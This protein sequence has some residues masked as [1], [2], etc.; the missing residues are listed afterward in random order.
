MPAPDLPPWKHLNPQLVVWHTTSHLA[1]RKYMD[2]LADINPGRC[3]PYTLTTVQIHS[4]YSFDAIECP[5]SDKHWCDATFRCKAL[6]SYRGC[7]M[8][9]YQREFTERKAFKCV[10]MKE[11]YIEPAKNR[12]ATFAK[13]LRPEAVQYLKGLRAQG[14]YT[15]AKEEKEIAE[16]RDSLFDVLEEQ[17]E[18]DSAVGES[19]STQRAASTEE[20]VDLFRLHEALN[21]MP[22]DRVAT[23]IESGVVLNADATM[24]CMDYS[25]SPDHADLE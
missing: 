20:L 9:L 6:T 3:T 14:L 7:D 13:C 25:R 24:R 19:S 10:K 1:C 8:G 22:T 5:P 18:S 11:L 4:A 23:E 21:H 15:D 16:L 2:Y 17:P 12:H